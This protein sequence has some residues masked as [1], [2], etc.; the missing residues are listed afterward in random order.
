V[1][2]KC[3]LKKWCGHLASVMTD[4]NRKGINPVRVVNSKGEFKIYGIAFKKTEKDRGLC[5]NFCPFC[6]VELTPEILGPWSKS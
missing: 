5:F 3:S 6:G 1:V 4:A 2:E